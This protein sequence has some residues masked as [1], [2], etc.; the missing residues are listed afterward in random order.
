MY[1][2]ELPHGGLQHDVERAPGDVG[3]EVD[4]SGAVVAVR[5]QGVAER[6]RVPVKHRHGVVQDAEVEGRGQQ[7]APAAPLVSVAVKKRRNK[8]CNLAFPGSFLKKELSSPEQ[9]SPVKPW[10]QEVVLLALLQVSWAAEDG[11]H[12]VRVVEDEYGAVT[13]DTGHLAGL[14]AAQAQLIQLHSNG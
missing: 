2:H 3:E 5:L 9:K 12:S 13:Q 7:L 4:V 8:R 14:A 6:V 10:K 1:V 11:L